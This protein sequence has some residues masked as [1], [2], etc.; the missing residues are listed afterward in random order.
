MTA[1]VPLRTGANI[2]GRPRGRQ[3]PAARDATPLAGC[4]LSPAG[5]SGANLRGRMPETREPPPC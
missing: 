5:K 3:P 2:L 1:P 4:G